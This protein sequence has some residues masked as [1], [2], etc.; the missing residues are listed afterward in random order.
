MSIKWWKQNSEIQ[1]FGDYISA[2]LHYRILENKPDASSNTHRSIGSVICNPVIKDDINNGASEISFFGCGARG[3][4]LNEDLKDFCRF[5]SVRGPLTRDLLGLASNTKLGDSAFILSELYSPKKKSEG[6]KD[7][8]VTHF[9]EERLQ[10]D[11]LATTGAKRVVSSKC[12]RNFPSLE[13]V[14][15]D[16]ASSSFVLTSSLHGAIIAYI[17]KVPFAFW[18]SGDVNV[19]FKWKDFS[20]SIGFECKFCKDL[21]EGKEW[22]GSIKD[23]IVYYDANDM[24]NE[25]KKFFEG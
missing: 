19:P 4:K 14:I 24:L 21:D 11:L 20:L 17:Y 15:D 23:H 3:N 5:G 9:N 13:G 18:D 22:Y 12:F 6:F 16:I 7:T 8:L 2:Y 1:N 25:Y 10:E